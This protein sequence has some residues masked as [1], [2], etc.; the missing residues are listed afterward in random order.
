MIRAPKGATTIRVSGSASN[1]EDMPESRSRRRSSLRALRHR[2][3]ALFFSG[4]LLSNCGTWFQNIA[5]ALLVYRLTHSPFW[6]GAANFAQFIGVVILAPWA[7]SAADRFNRRALIVG[8]QL[9]ATVVSAALAALVAAGWGTLPVVLGLALL[10]G[11][12]TAFSTPAL[13]AILPALVPRE[14]LGAAVAMN[15][16][17]F[18]LA[19]AVGPVA[20]ALVV[21]RLGIPWAIGVNALSY[22]A[23]AA[24]VLVVHPAPQT[25]RSE[26]ARLRD[27]IRM[28]REDHFLAVLLVVVAA[29]SLTMDPVSTLTPSFATRFF[30][31]PDTWAG[32]LIGAFGAGAVIASVVP[33]REGTAPERRIG[34]MLLLLGGGMIAF[35][36]TPSV[37]IAFPLLAVAGFGYLI[38]QT[39]AT[40]LLQLEVSDEERGRVMALWSIAFLGSRPLASLLDGGL[41][42]LLGPRLATVLMTLPTVAVAALLLSG[43]AP[44]GAHGARRHSSGSEG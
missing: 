28:V 29:V 17:T 11:F 44:A 33:L 35:G 41:A 15:S 19:R 6:V 16:V 25:H 21:A 18:N 23:L 26:H 9:G 40:T 42:S 20:G 4:N 14:D 22:L 2:D 1:S 3:F 10:L 30:H 7:G 24:A 38:G 32:Y 37:A 27:S 8:T 13:Q 39:S 36:L 43:H 34:G 12:T 5:L 31:H